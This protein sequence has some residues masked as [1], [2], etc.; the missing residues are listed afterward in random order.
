[1]IRIFTFKVCLSGSH[2]FRYGSPCMKH[3]FVLVNNK[4]KDQ[5]KHLYKVTS[6]FAHHSLESKISSLA[7][8]FSIFLLIS[9][10]EQPFN[11]VAK[12]ARQLCKCRG[13]YTL[14][15]FIFLLYQQY[16]TPVLYDKED[17]SQHLADI[18]SN[19]TCI[20]RKKDNEKGEYI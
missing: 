6:V 15:A 8:S 7:T 16:I 11:S 9:V 3:V 18:Q 19:L 14:F 1:M 12:L 4:V 13:S 20:R 2:G 10:Y 5:L 17:R